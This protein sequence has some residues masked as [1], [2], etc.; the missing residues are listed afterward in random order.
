MCQLDL[1]LP[2]A[3]YYNETTSEE[4]EKTVSDLIHKRV[5]SSLE[6]LPS[7]S[8]STVVNFPQSDSSEGNKTGNSNGGCLLPDLN[9]MPCEDESGSETLYGMS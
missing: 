9:M 8:N 3:K 7:S 2:S 5:A 1:G 4:P 6:N